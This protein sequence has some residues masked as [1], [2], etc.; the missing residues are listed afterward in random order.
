MKRPRPWVSPDHHASHEHLLWFATPAGAVD[1]DAIIVPTIRPPMALKHVVGLAADLRRPL[2]VL[3]SGR[4]T[5]ARRMT[6]FADWGAEIVAI[7]VPERRR[8]ALPDFQ[9]TN[10]LAGTRFERREDTSVKR[11]VALALARL[12]RWKRIL[13]LDDDIEV[14]SSEDLRRAAGLLDDDFSA[15]GMRIDGFPDNSVVCHAYRAVGGPQQS[16]VGGGALAVATGKDA[17]FFPAIYNEDWFYLLEARKLRRL[18]VTGKVF[19]APYDPFRTPDRARAEELGDVL[20]EGVFWLLDEGKTLQEADERHWTEFLA[21][22]KRFITDVLT[23]VPFCD[24]PPDVRQRM[25]DALRAARG[26]L[27]LISPELCVAY[28]AAWRADRDEWRAF[29]NRLKPVRRWKEALARLG[30]TDH[31]HINPHLSQM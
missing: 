13:F 5:S 21:R 9:T 30:V 4:W 1:P 24:E 17:S 15:V 12:L 23:R 20:A 25:Q 27:D 3:C 10:L 26:R 18:G 28:L 7:D 2:V 29:L 14:D 19:Q 16:F 8:L 22:R 31:E 11:N 6:E